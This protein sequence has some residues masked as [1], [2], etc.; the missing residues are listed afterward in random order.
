MAGLAAAVGAGYFLVQ[1]IVL[2]K[3][4]LLWRVRRKLI[5]S[6]IFIGFVPALLLVAFLLLCGFL[7]FLQL[8]LV[9]RAEPA[10]SR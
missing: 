2:A 5:I 1:L 7:L 9:P 8:Q 6:Y 10:A 3:R 4:R